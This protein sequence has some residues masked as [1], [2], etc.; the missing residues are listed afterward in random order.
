MTS[1]LRALSALALLLF[2]FG[3]PSF[4]YAD[5]TCNDIDISPS[6]VFFQED[7][8]GESI[9][10]TL[11]NDGDDRF[12]VDDVRVK[13]TSPFFDLSL[14]DFPDEVDEDDTEKI[15]LRYDTVDVEGEEEDTFQIEIKGEF[16]DENETCG[17]SDLSFTIHVTIEDGADVCTLIDISASDATVVE[18]ESVNHT[19][20]LKN[21][22]G[23]AFTL[24]GFNVFDDSGN[25]SAA[26]ETAFSDNDFD[27]N[28]SAN[29]TQ[30]YTVEINAQNV[31]E[32][33]TDVVFIEARGEFSDGTDCSFNT[34]DDEFDVTVI[35]TGIDSAVCADIAIGTTLLNISANQTEST[36]I[37]I[38]NTSAQDY[39][40][41]EITIT[42]T[43]YQFHT[44]VIDVPDV[45]LEGESAVVQIE[46]IGYD[47][48]T[49]FDA[50][51]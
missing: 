47:Y 31:S 44:G 39:F 9:T 45:V 23:L 24:L 21:N 28:I 17:F 10:F 4:V 14:I 5:S 12:E 48:P 36:T 51:G 27:K 32:D 46:T 16:D 43:N 13:E 7:E 40:I 42:D 25:F 18:G 6:S 1:P 30:N 33:E 50:N 29:Q 22:S 37:S 20:S 34:I 19:I 2:S 11:E 49:S 41:D 35:D 8:D 15:R 38:A 3:M 26:L